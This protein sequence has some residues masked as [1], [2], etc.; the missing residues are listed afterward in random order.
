MTL[1]YTWILRSDFGLHHF[2]VFIPTNT[3]DVIKANRIKR[4][5]YDQGLVPN[6]KRRL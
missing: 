6:P 5:T 4:G 1:T 3:Q 2:L